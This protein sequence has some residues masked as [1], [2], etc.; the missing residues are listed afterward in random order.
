MTNVKHGL[1]KRY[2]FNRDFTVLIIVKYLLV[3]VIIEI[4]WGRLRDLR[5]KFLEKFDKKSI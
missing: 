4:F 2:D 1:S 5:R 3:S